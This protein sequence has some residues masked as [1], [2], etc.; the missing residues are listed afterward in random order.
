M[1]GLL[2]H[3][4]SQPLEAGQRLL[5][6]L[7]L[8]QCQTENT[9]GALVIHASHQNLARLVLRLRMIACGDARKRNP[10]RFFT[11]ELG[12]GTHSSANHDGLEKIRTFAG[13]LPNSDARSCRKS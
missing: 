11:G 6:L 1:D 13:C 4:R 3:G 9:Q 7:L 5:E 10:E 12:I 2:W 8:K